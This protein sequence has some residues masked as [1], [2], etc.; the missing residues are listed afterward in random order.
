MKQLQTEIITL[1]KIVGGGQAMGALVDGRKAFVWG[2]L[3]GEK[4]EVQ[5]TKKKSKLV[6]AVVTR[7][8]EA[9]KER[10]EA[11]DPESYL[12]SSPVTQARDVALLAE[13]YG[14]AHHQGYNFFPRTPHIEHLVV[15]DL[16]AQ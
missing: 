4:V 8:I 2:G 1:D 10:I 15:L 11:K 14:I 6:E 9:S 13:T 16:I 7:V 3:P 5:I 12:S